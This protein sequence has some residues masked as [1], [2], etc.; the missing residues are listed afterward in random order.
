M[1]ID[2][3]K[4]LE[5]FCADY[6]SRLQDVLASSDWSGVAQLAQNMRE[7]WATG[8]QV[9]F[10]GNGGSA[11]NAIHLAND[12]LYGIAKRTGGGMKV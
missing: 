2:T 10:C 3:H 11:G 4:S 7:C 6:A 8:R 9:F 5:E 1:N 12:F